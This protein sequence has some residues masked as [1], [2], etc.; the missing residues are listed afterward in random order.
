MLPFD[1]PD[2]PDMGPSGPIVGLSNIQAFNQD[3]YPRHR[4]DP[5][6]SEAIAFVIAVVVILAIVFVVRRAIRGVQILVAKIR[7]RRTVRRAA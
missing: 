5:L 3:R 7:A 2:P 6:V 1:L 4:M